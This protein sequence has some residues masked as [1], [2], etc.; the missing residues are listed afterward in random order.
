M[1]SEK[2]EER[3]NI[4]RLIKASGQGASAETVR[5]YGEASKAAPGLL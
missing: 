5:W 4:E 3:G 1:V 2:K